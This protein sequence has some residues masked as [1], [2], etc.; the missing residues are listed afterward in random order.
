MVQ[1]IL[2][3][4]GFDVRTEGVVAYKSDTTSEFRET[5]SK[6]QEDV[7][8][9]IVKFWTIPLTLSPVRILFPLHFLRARIPPPQHRLES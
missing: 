5:K 2:N 3:Q 7:L 9:Y 6:G 1:E 8:N 4:Y